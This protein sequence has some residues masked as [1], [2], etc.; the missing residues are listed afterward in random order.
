MRPADRTVVE[1]V[2]AVKTD[3]HVCAGHECRVAEPAACDAAEFGR[4]LVGVAV[5]GC[6]HCLL[7]GPT[8]GGLTPS[9]PCSSAAT[10]CK[11]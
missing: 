6:R 3:S 10:I 5:L 8:V 11:T 7:V 4:Q 2:D 9:S 1:L